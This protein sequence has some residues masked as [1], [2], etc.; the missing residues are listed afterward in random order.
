MADEVELAEKAI[1]R[2]V[3]VGVDDPEIRLSFIRHFESSLEEFVSLIWKAHK[4]WKKL[5]STVRGSEER[6]HISSLVYGVIN[7]QAHISFLNLAW[8]PSDVRRHLYSCGYERDEDA[9]EVETQWVKHK[10][11]HFSYHSTL[12]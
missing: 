8:K 9:L 11:N 3:L 2:T 6:A 4:R 7:N 5:D 10:T 1:I 12:L